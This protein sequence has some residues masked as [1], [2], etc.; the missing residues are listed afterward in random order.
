MTRP[1][2]KVWFDKMPESNGKTNWTVI[3]HREGQ[4][5]SEGICIY[6]SE[7]PDRARYEADHM[8]WLIGE[9]EAEPDILAYDPDLHS[10]YVKPE[11]PKC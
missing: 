11:P 3:L 5:I 2:M 7:Y 4:C 6:R 10:G 8:K 9:N 1:I